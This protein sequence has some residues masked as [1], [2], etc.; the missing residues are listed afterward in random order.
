MELIGIFFVA[1]GL[2]VIAGV[3]KALR[4]DDT[5][6]ALVQLFPRTPS[7]PPTLSLMRQVI[8]IG[9]V[10]EAVVGTLA[11]LFPTPLPAALVAASYAAFVCT[12][13]YARTRGGPLST[14]GCFGRPDTPATGFHVVLNVVFL[15]TAVA[16]IARPPRFSNLES[17]L[18]HQ[19]WIGAPLLLACSAGVW[20]A[21]LALSPLAALEAARRLTGR[22]D[23]R[24]LSS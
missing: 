5:A 6:R 15:A 19:P 23:S 13:A 16:V 14:C 9:A 21:Y 18:A 17:L 1:C 2:L 7:R 24:A 10:V 20:F 12:V 22:H 3:A 8:R 4:P 11:L